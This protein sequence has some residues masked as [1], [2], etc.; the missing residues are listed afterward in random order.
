MLFK[1]R[2][3]PELTEISIVC[4]SL[5]RAARSFRR[6]DSHSK[7]AIRLFFVRRTNVE[8]RA[9]KLGSP[10]SAIRKTS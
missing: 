2:A 8:Q 6:L 7:F 3:K 4:I 5:W 10:H 9:R 1:L